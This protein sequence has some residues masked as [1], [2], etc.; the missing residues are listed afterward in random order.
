MPSSF[1]FSNAT[2]TLAAVEP[3]FET[4]SFYL[5]LC[6]LVHIQRSDGMYEA[7]LNERLGKNSPTHL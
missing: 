1:F 5:N 4:S 6:C 7:K 2:P 3:E